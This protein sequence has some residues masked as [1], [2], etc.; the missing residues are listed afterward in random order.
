VAGAIGMNFVENCF[1][2]VFCYNHIVAIGEGDINVERILGGF[3]ISAR[4][5][6]A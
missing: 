3:L 6:G 4:D 1:G 5:I 2:N